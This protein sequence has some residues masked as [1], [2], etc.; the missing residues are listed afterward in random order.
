MVC[1]T[2]WKPALVCQVLVCVCV[3]VCVCN[4]VKSA[5]SGVGVGRSYFQVGPTRNA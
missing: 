5:D 1:S 2:R 4:N 3:C